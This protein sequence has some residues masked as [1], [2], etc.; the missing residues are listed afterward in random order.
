[1]T[2]CQQ[3]NSNLIT[4]GLTP[5]QQIFCAHCRNLSRFGEI[6]KVA[7]DRL[8]W[9][10]FW[11]GLSSIVLLFFTGIPAIYFGIKSLL[12]MRFVKPKSSDRTAAIA[13]TAMGGCFGVLMGSTIIAGLL[14]A[15]FIHLGSERVN[16]PALVLE[17]CKTNFE[18]QQPRDTV[19]VLAASELGNMSEYLFA[20]SQEP[21]DRFA[22]IHL[23]YAGQGIRADRRA[24][25]LR[26]SNRRI[27][28]D[29]E[30]DHETATVFKW[31]MDGSPTSVNY[32][33]YAAHLDENDP[34]N[35]APETHHYYGFLERQGEYYGISV[36]FDPEK[37]KMTES[38]VKQIFANTKLITH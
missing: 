5:G 23:L 8:A 13:G 30:R 34:E 32:K 10:S 17:K 2:Q 6:E 15:L 14:I 24:F 18:F 27:T 29:D 4:D 19:P 1:M 12:R 37:R 16:E 22:C 25:I 3:C 26:L 11:L 35:N 28:S 33:I 31:E 21:K 38:E 20:D 7:T 9:R 36:A